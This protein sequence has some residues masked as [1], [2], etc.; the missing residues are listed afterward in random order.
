VPSRSHRPSQ[1]ATSTLGQ[2]SAHGS[3]ARVSSNGSSKE[4]ARLPLYRRLLFPLEDGT[5]AVPQLI[6][7]EGKHVVE[8]NEK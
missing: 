8:I 5:K 6:K 4:P 1:K 7:G 2:Q 3:N